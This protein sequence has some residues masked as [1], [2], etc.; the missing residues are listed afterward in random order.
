MRRTAKAADARSDSRR[1]KRAA[2]IAVIVLAAGASTRMG[3][4]KQLLRYRGE[5]LLRRA[6]NA[7]LASACRPVVVVTGAQP[8]ASCDQL[9]DTDARIAVNREWAEGMSSSIRC[10]IEAVEAAATAGAIDAAV[11]TLC[12]Q[13]FVTGVVLDRLVHAYLVGTSPLVVSEYET[14][15]ETTRGVPALFGRSL[16]PELVNLRGSIGAKPVIERHASR[17]I[18]VRVPEAAFDID[19]PRDYRSLLES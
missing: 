8:Y 14:D 2:N 13:P 4:P 17:A 1:V 19:T 5:T 15:G 16:F 11:I 3:E 6:T 9:A 12:D 18:V 10:G 7:A